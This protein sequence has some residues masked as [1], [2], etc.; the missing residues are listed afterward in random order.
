METFGKNR[1]Q[2]QRFN[3]KILTT[4]N[5][6]IY[7]YQDGQT[8]ATLAAQY[9]ESEFDRITELLGYTPF[10]RTR[11]FIFNSVPEMTQSNIGLGVPEG[12]DPREINL[13]KSRVLAAFSGNQVEFKRQLIQGIAGV[14]VYDMLYGGSLKESLQSSLLLTL[15]D[16]FMAGI[17][18]YI[19]EGWS[20]RMDDYMRE[21]ILDKRLR[22]P[23]ILAGQEARNVGH[24]IWNYIA[25]RYGRDNISNILNLTRIIRNEQTSIASTLGVSYSRFLREWRDYYGNMAS[26]LDAYQTAKYDLKIVGNSFDKGYKI[27]R[28]RL[29]ADQQYIAY[30]SND[31]GRF[32]VEVVDTRK[33]KDKDRMIVLTGGQKSMTQAHNDYNPLIS[34]QK[35]NTLAV[36]YEENNQVFLHLYGFDEKTGKKLKLRKPL[37]SISQVNDFDISDDGSTIVMS[38]EKKGQ[39][40]LY[41]YRINANVT[42]QLTNDLYDD[43]N[44]QFVGRSTSQVAFVSNRL[45]DTLNVD[46]GNYK[47]LNAQFSLFLHSGEAKAEL[48]TRVIDSLG[49]ISRPIAPSEGLF[50]FMSDEKGI[51]NVYRYE[52]ESQ[53]LTQITNFKY[54]LL[55]YDLNTASGALVYLTSEKEEEFVGYL[56]KGDLSTSMSL[57]ATQRSTLM[58]QAS[59][60]LA[61]RSLAKVEVATP[62]PAAPTADLEKEKTSLSRGIALLPGE[63][64]TDNYQFDIESFKTVERRNDKNERSLRQGKAETAIRNAR[65]ETIR[66][67]GPADYQDMFLYNGSTGALVIDP[68]PMRGLGYSTSL[69]M[70]DLLEN[71]LMKAGLFI[72]P[73]LR[74][75]DLFAEYS[76]LPNRIDY[77]VRV[78]RRTFFLD[79]PSSQKYRYNRIAFS[80]SYPISQT[81]RLMLSPSYSLTRFINLNEISFTDR[82]SEYA[83]LRG[84]VVFDNTTTNG[85]YMLEGTRAKFRADYY[86]GLTSSNESFSRVSIDVRNYFKIH[87]EMILATRFSASTS[88]GPAPKQVFMGGVDNWLFNRYDRR[89]IDDPL[90]FDLESS[91]DKRDLFFADFA[92]TLRG[93]NLNKT[94]G[95]SHLLLNVELRMPLV[96]YFYRGPITSNFL[97]NFQ[98]VAFSDIGTA[99]SGAGPFEKRFESPIPKPN[100]FQ[101]SVNTFKNPFLIGYGA[102]ARTMLF[103]Y[104]AKL[105]VAWGIE[106]KIVN[107]P[108]MYLSLG[109]D[110]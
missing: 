97:R 15:P 57:P 34:W 60:G 76:F 91:F 109:R 39:N 108:M 72:T 35:N 67:K 42:Q 93:F 17:E 94:S 30:A 75:S 43:L 98:L 103:G 8:S 81:T 2:Y 84:E 40:D 59:S 56:S 66:I 37:K 53:Q 50:Y 77:S 16:W 48:V 23:S 22:K 3:W 87:R 105:D 19:A 110:F 51:R 29:S 6:E 102:G 7:Y 44:P 20:V 99:W 41:L 28:V 11:I 45:N 70:N 9:A 27:N 47:T 64:D 95:R 18:S 31:Y 61:N 74:N 68:L 96:K 49:V 38:A 107:S 10:N 88:G 71:H 89:N 78:D 90:N 33:P 13:Q 101:A 106:D 85:M 36:I 92:T 5:F 24:A 54:N 69:T 65:K 55:D 25:E 46:K 12:E 62:K 100:P 1:I 73:N 26:Q 32:T 82:T 79:D 83:G 104:Y 86:Q 4:A 14:F 63:V 21:V 52:T 58:G 80:A